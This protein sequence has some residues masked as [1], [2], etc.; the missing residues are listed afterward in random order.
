MN[1]TDSKHYHKPTLTASPPCLPATCSYNN[2]PG[3]QY[4][5]QQIA[6]GDIRC[7]RIVL[8]TVLKMADLSCLLSV[9]GEI[10]LII[11]E[12]WERCDEGDVCT[13]HI[14]RVGYS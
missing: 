2:V 14:V 7:L 13:V 10:S 1:R 11:A 3:P 5:R 4:H 8:L 9:R 12:I 6:T